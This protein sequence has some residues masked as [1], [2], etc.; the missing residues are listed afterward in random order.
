M[1]GVIG[2]L[3]L[4]AMLFIIC[5]CTLIYIS[6]LRVLNLEIEW[7]NALQAIFSVYITVDGKATDTVGF[8]EGEVCPDKV[9]QLIADKDSSSA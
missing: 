7:S 4:R 2:N 6:R 9:Y 8:V 1:P 5:N 3:N